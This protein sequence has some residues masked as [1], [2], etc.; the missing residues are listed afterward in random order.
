MANYMQLLHLAARFFTLASLLLVALAPG[1][2]A[3]TTFTVTNTNDNGNGS[4]RKAIQ[5]ANGNEGADV[6]VFDIPGA[7]PHTIQPAS[8]LPT[9]TDA[10][11]IDGYSQPGSEANTNP[12][13]QGLN[14][15]LMVEL[16]GTNAGADTDGLNIEADDCTVRGLVINRFSRDGINLEG[17]DNIAE[18]NFIGTNVSGTAALPNGD[19]GVSVK[20]SNNLIGGITADARNVISGSGDRGIAIGA[21]VTLNRIQG[22]LIGTD[23]SG[24]VSLGNVNAGV[25]MFGASNNTIGG[26][27]TGARNVISGND[28]AGIV[29]FGDASGNIIEGNYIGTDVTGTI[30]LGNADD[31]V[32]IDESPNNTVGGA[33]AGQGNVI[34]GNNDDGIFI[35]GAASTSNIIQGN[36]IGTQADGM[37]PLGNRE[38]GIDFSSAFPASDNTIGGSSSGE[39]NVIAFNG[40]RG[41]FVSGGTNNALRR[42]AIFMNAALGM[43]VGAPAGRTSNDPGD[44]DAGPNNLQNFP[45]MASAFA[46]GN[47][48]SIEYL[49][50]SSTANSV[51]P[52]TIEFFLADADEEE[53]MTF[54][55][56]ATYEAADARRHVSADIAVQT[57][58]SDGYMIV[59]TAT[60]ADGNTS[61]FSAALEV[62]RAVNQS[63][64]A[65]NDTATTP[66]NTAIDIEVLANDTD[67]DGDALAV[68]V[69]TQPANGTADVLADQRI[70]YMPN[71]G[72]NGED[73]F[74]YQVD[75]GRGGTA[76]A[77]V[78]VTVT[79]VNN[80]PSASEITSPED[81]AE[82]TVGGAP[83]SDPLDPETAFMVIWTDATDPDGDALS[84]T[85]QLSASEAFAEVLFQQETAAATQVET[86]LGVVAGLLDA[87]GVMLGA[88]TTLYHRV[89]ASDGTA[90]T[91]GPV[92]SVTL[93]RGT[94]TD[95]ASGDAMPSVF[96]LE[97]AYPNPFNPQT[98][99]RFT[100]PHATQTRLA[101]FDLL[102]REVAVLIEGTLPGGRHEA[103]FEAPSLPSGAYLYRLEA[104]AFTQTR[105]M[106]LL[107]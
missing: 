18:G 60:D 37:S 69:S 8:T 16:D 15:V 51:Y 53:G 97:A 63:P 43:D 56:S 80:A 103:V 38:D 105:S 5:D 55:G 102:G 89:V 72:F 96:A 28:A 76:S 9:I 75:D 101:V 19:D 98:L 33:G 27:A 47:M 87:A 106:L 94:L 79:D 82:I 77:T 62:Q 64:T 22:N 81:G 36:L 41:V 100:L 95:V 10:V 92:S 57:T 71:A 104:G 14:T 70:R 67:P 6:I 54:I 21:G 48:L 65:Q 4:L 2:Q 85:W 49:V 42:N 34:S 50:P 44:G 24:T 61:E 91:E 20:G 59:A 84:Y 58:L 23:A 1:V 26:A 78:T 99:I 40:A 12:I 45:E 46:T 31:G 11:M 25:S 3:Q 88:S 74:T 86:T 7:G 107:K 35:R 32:F 39:G 93:V 83:G 17:T 90:T 30:G 73:V 52:L 68:S 29:L 13:D 66:E